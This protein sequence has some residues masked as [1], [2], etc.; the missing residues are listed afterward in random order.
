MQAIQSAVKEEVVLYQRILGA[1]PKVVV[2]PTFAWTRAVE[3]AWAENGVNC[4]VTP[5]WR[6]TRR[7]ASG[8]M[9]G[10]EGPIAN[11]DRLGNLVYLARSE[12]FEPVRGRGANHALRAL[13]Q[14]ASHG[15]PCLLE[16]HR[17]NFIQGPE[18]SRASLAELDKLY[19]LALESYGNLRFL[20]SKELAHILHTRDPA[21]IATRVGQR[22]P[23]ILARLRNSGRFWKL[24]RV[25][26]LAGVLSMFVGMIGFVNAR[27]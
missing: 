16:N 7:N 27:T 11:G 23:A 6:Y 15:R 1:I 13:A 10:E 24:A 12:Y 17:D 8:A 19:Q 22:L 2:P 25:T 18:E 14:D 3:E 4:V 21:W 9:E 20:S 26:G 5:G